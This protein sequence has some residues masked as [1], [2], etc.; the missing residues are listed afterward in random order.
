MTPNVFPPADLSPNTRYVFTVR[1]RNKHWLSRPATFTHVI[2]TLEHG[3]PDQPGVEGDL[4]PSMRDIR[5]KLTSATVRLVSVEA[6][7]STTLKVTWRVLVDFDSLEGVYVRYRPLDSSRG[8]TVGALSVETIHFPLRG[9]RSTII[10]NDK[11]SESLSSENIYSHL[12]IRSGYK[13]S[14]GNVPT[15]HIISS[16]S[17]GTTYE[18]FVV[19]FYREIEGQPTSAMRRTTL[20]APIVTIPTGVHYR[21][22]NSST[23]RIGWDPLP[24]TM[25]VGGRLIGYN[26]QV[27]LKR[28]K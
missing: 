17:P 24:P 15:S 6:V 8:H 11:N 18:V 25:E 27:R 20:P 1:S 3:Q 5:T 23:V 16:L 26:V 12:D 14:S 2:K 9:E 13:Q 28:L 10:D 21:Q 19:P 22:V 4:S 7:S